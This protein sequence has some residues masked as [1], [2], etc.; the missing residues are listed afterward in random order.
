MNFIAAKVVILLE[1]TKLFTLFII[2]F[3]IYLFP[4]DHAA[5]RLMRG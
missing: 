1:T 5:T 2:L 3:H 4:D